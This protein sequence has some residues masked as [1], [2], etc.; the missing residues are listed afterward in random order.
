MLVMHACVRMCVLMCVCAYVLMCIWGRTILTVSFLVLQLMLANE[1]ALSKDVLAIPEHQHAIHE[2]YELIEQ[3]EGQKAE[4]IKG[5]NNVARAG[6]A[7]VGSAR[8]TAQLL[9]PAA[10]E[11]LLASAK[12]LS[13]A[14]AAAGG[15][16]KPAVSNVQDHDAYRKLL[17][18]VARVRDAADNLVDDAGKA[19]AFVTLQRAA[20]EAAA[21]TTALVS[22]SRAASHKAKDEP[23]KHRLNEEAARA[24]AALQRLLDAVRSAQAKPDNIGEQNKLLG[25]AQQTAMPASALVVAAKSAIPRV[26]DMATKMQLNQDSTAAQRDVQ[27]MIAAIRRV[28]EATGAKEIETAQQEADV[29]IMGSEALLLSAEVGMLE[30]TSA[31]LDKAVQRL[32]AAANGLN[33]AAGELRET[34][35]NKPDRI[36]VASKGVG[37]AVHGVAEAAKEVAYSTGDKTVQIGVLSG[38]KTVGV[39]TKEQINAA[40][41]KMLNPTDPGA[42]HDLESATQALRD[43]LAALLASSQGADVSSKE[44]DEAIAVIQN[45]M[46]HINPAAPHPGMHTHSDNFTKSIFLSKKSNSKKTCTLSIEVFELTHYYHRLRLGQ[47]R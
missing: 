3:S 33:G 7:L 9:D 45:E 21:S 20:K 32:N 39:R 44:C 26:D 16:A 8:Q 12:A 11:R 46:E 14:T 35:I 2:G 47:G 31:A 19:V 42:Q 15:A 40:K 18:A 22:S 17:A 30:P 24:Q 5:A 4:L 23:T 43:A 34:A 37:A 29:A 41:A 10:Q 1:V 25:V 13:E 27:A 6:L 38:A 36:G 28:A